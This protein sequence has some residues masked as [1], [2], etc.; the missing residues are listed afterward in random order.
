MEADFFDRVLRKDRPETIE[1]SIQYYTMGQGEWHTT[2]IWPPPGLSTERLYFGDRKMLNSAAPSA[3]NASDSY[4]VAFAA[5]TGKQNIWATGFGGGDVVYFDCANEDKRLLVYTSAPLEA[6]LEATGTPVLTIEMSSSTS[7]GAVHAYLE[8]VSP[9][10]RVTYLD[11]GILRLID[12]REVDPKSLPYKPLGPAHSCLRKD[13]EPMP[14]GDIQ[15]VRF[16]LYLT[17]VVLRK[18][19]RIRIALAGADSSV[20]RRYPADGTPTW[21]VYRETRHASFLELPARPTQETSR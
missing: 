12:R 16:S 7:D 18:G 21:K 4:T 15:R 5:T 14:P 3:P 2:A 6:D 11:E 20:F 8:D 13:A 19:H 17:S 1:S 9:E 10:G